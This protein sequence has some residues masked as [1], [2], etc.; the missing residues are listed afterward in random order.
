VGSDEHADTLA[1]ECLTFSRYLIGRDAAPDVVAAYRKAHHVSP[2]D[3]SVVPAALDAALLTV[4]RWGPGFARVA[5]GYAAVFAKASRLRRKLVLMVAI[6]ESRG[7]TAALIDT[8]TPGSTG[9]WVAEVSARFATGACR[10]GLA[11]LLIPAVRVWHR[12]V[13]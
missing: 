4:A 9:A 6:L 5:D 11:L 3:E 1:A 12:L 8:A 2:V 10:L 13:R 7:A